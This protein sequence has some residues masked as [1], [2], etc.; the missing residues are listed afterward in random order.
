ME[1]VRYIDKISLFFFLRPFFIFTST[2]SF[3][4]K[5]VNIWDHLTHT[6]NLIKDG[7]TG[8]VA[9]NSYNLHKR[10][11]EML[12]ELGV[13]YY[14]FSLSWSR[15]LP[16][17][18]PN[19]VSEDGLRYYNALIDD[20]LRVNVTP[21]VTIYHWDLPNGLQELGGWTN[22]LMD[23]Y[24][25][26]Y[27]DVVFREFGQKVKVWLTFNEPLVFCQQGYGAD[28]KAPVLNMSG[29]GE[30]LCAH[31]VLKAHA[32]VYHLY[33]EVYR[34]AQNGTKIN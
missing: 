8:D 28:G 32:K 7:T 6:T 11:V 16:S 27:A 18:F 9:C 12:T 20:L 34:L 4:D 2:C 23:E 30:Y 15:I 21:V 3:S 29:V 24:F 5:G 17:G 33:D 19:K 13:N 31:T 1:R 25:A 10:D 22:P 26:D 14:R